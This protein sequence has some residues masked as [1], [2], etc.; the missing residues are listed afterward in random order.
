MRLILS[1]TI[2]I[3]I[4]MLLVG[5]TTSKHTIFGDQLPTMKSIHDKKFGRGDGAPNSKL[6]SRQENE[7]N[8]PSPD[9]EWLAN[10]VITMYVNKHLSPSGLPVP[11][12]TTFF[13]LYPKD[14]IAVSGDFLEP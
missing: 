13:K 9:F 7:P 8:S 14:H 12:Y 3:L 6:P 10:P 2:M 1:L 11:G 4:N 5:C